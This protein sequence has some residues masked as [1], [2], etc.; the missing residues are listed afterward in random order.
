MVD[1]KQHPHLTHGHVNTSHASQ[2]KTVDRVL[3][4]MGKESVP[5]V[6]AEQLYVSV[7]RVRGK[8]TIYT[9]LP[10]QELRAAF[11][12]QDQRQSAT[13]VF[14]PRPRRTYDLVRRV[15]QAWRQLTERAARAIQERMY[16]YGR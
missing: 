10:F 13:S 4:A 1:P 9:N 2:G 8:A 3:I 7:R 11:Q 12:R 5:A 14:Q 6:S 15:K 16:S